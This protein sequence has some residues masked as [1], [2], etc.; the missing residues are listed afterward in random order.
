MAIEFF[1]VLSVFLERVSRRI[2]ALTTQLF[3]AQ[4]TSV[5]IE[6][7]IMNVIL[8]FLFRQHCAGSIGKGFPVTRLFGA[9]VFLVLL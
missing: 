9:L 1:Q 5:T 4:Q 7:D 8:E 6:V 3:G 2:Q